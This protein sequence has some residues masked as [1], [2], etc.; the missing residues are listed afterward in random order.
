MVARNC[1]PW[2][3][4]VATT[5]IR[6]LRG[7]GRNSSTP[8]GPRS[9]LPAFG[10]QRLG[11]NCLKF[12]TYRTHRRCFSLPITQLVFGRQRITV[13]HKRVGVWRGYRA[14]P[15]SE[16]AVQPDASKRKRKMTWVCRSLADCARC[17]V[18]PQQGAF[19]CTESRADSLRVTF[20]FRPMA[21][22]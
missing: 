22:T 2:F 3:C 6:V 21:I 5:S 9:G 16:S 17:C 7:S 13:L 8:L 11:W 20:A 15:T 10:D 1:A 19:D 4:F 12:M 14:P 18:Y